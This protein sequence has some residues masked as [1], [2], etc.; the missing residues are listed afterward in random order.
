[1]TA[2][3]EV[4]GDHKSQKFVSP[5]KKWSNRELKAVF[6]KKSVRVERWYRFLEKHDLTGSEETF[7]HQEVVIQRR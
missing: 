4:K 6:R 3:L 5:M 1:M 2:C 7:S